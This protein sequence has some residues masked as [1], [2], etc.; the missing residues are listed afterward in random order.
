[1]TSYG[2]VHPLD[3]AYDTAHIF[4]VLR[5][6]GSLTLGTSHLSVLLY[7]GLSSISS[8]SPPRIPLI[9]DNM[10]IQDNLGYPQT[11]SPDNVDIRYIALRPLS[12]GSYWNYHCF[13][14]IYR[15]SGV[16]S[17]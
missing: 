4:I 16:R 17:S 10:E 9:A 11:F 3:T 6:A 5:Q 2:T 7:L 8:L 15:A 14:L 12:F 13:I 1:M